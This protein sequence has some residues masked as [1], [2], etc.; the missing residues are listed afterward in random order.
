VL[1]C[2]V[3]VLFQFTR[4]LFVFGTPESDEGY[5][6]VD[7]SSPSPGGKSPGQ[8]QRFSDSPSRTN[9]LQW[10][11]VRKSEGKKTTNQPK[12]NKKKK[13]TEASLTA[14]DTLRIWCILTV[15]EHR[16]V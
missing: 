6:I 7:P 9:E 10:V 11:G 5:F 4:G 14:L 8:C 13:K 1:V 12:K 3:D 15:T 16:R 2:I